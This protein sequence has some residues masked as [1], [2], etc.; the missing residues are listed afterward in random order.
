MSQAEGS[1]CKGGVVGG[2]RHKQETEG[3]VDGGQT[4]QAEVR[5]SVFILRVM[6]SY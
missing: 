2:T 4:K 6:D 1:E 5:A 3:E